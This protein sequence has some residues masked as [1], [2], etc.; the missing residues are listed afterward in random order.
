MLLPVALILATA[1]APRV[2]PDFE[3]RDTTDTPV[4][5]SAVARNRVAVVVFLGTDCPVAKLYTARLNDLTA[6]FPAGAVTVLTI[7]PNRGDDLPELVEFAREHKLTFP[8]LRDPDGRVAESFG[9][10]RSPQAFV[11]DAERRIRYQGRIDDQYT[12][13]GKNSGAPSREDLVEALLAV[14]A[15]KTVAV[16]ITECTG[17]FL[18]KPRPSTEPPRVTYARDIA[19][20][21]ATHCQVCHRPGEVAPF[22]LLSY[23]DAAR[24]AETIAEV[25]A[26]GTMPPWHANPTHGRF[27][28][29]RRLSAEQKRLIA[30]WVRLKCP[31]GEPL[32]P[33][34]VPK[35][36]GWRIGTPDAVYAIPREFAVPAE[37]IIEYQHFVVDPGFGADTW[38]RAAEVRPG[39]R[40]V[41]H[42]CSVFL[43][44]PGANRT[45]EFF[46]TGAL[47]SMNLIAFTPGSEPLRFP[48]GMA[49]CVPAGWRLHFIVH[50][51]AVGSPQTDRT[52]LAIQ[53]LPPSE[54]R[55]E[56]A[57]KL[58]DDLDL[59]I[60]PHAAN[61]RVERTWTADRDY[62]L[63]SLLPHM[64]LRGKSF[65]YTAE[66]PDGTSEVLLDVPAYDFNWQHRYELAEP[67]LIPTGTVIRCSAVYDNSAANP[68][69]PDPTAT[70]RAGEQSADEMFNGYFEIVAVDQDLQA[71]RATAEKKRTRSQW[72][73][74]GAVGFGGLWGIRKWR[75]RRSV[76]LTPANEPPPAK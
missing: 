36:S 15:N 38:V 17:C 37:G 20:I 2:V 14:L 43:L 47:G 69:N 11:L 1:L 59:V 23:A 4:R 48:D 9:A 12:A 56:V 7:D 57:T 34:E 75:K 74:A 22:S 40:R 61:H 26:N 66:Y 31:E 44:P 64:H 28:N 65:R 39:N 21:L 70:V 51:T 52:E 6:R 72:L 16:P 68:F 35:S 19:P 58:L 24:H 18:S 8:L 73:L 50:Y 63:L 49:K 10:T 76:A 33:V 54:V 45:D 53:F 46:E 55:K 32:S 3:L 25:V 30:E 71:E 27:R 29:D 5:F 60:P 67:K 42:H 41:V 62:L 13:G